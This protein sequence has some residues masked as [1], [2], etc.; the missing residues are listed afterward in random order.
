MTTPSRPVMRYL[1]GKWRLAPWII[2]FFPA[3]RT[4]VEPF[5]GAASV[6]LRK[7]RAHAEILNDLDGE[8]VNLFRVLRSP[9]DGRELARQ[10]R[11]TPFARREYEAAFLSAGDPIEQA[12]RTL[13][14][15]AMG[16]GSNS[17][18]KRTG[19]RPGHARTGQIPAGD[20]SGL[21]ASLEQAIERLRGVVVE[22]R[23]ALEVIRRYDSAKTLHY[24]DPPYPHGARGDD[25]RYRCEMTD[26][27]HAELAEALHVVRGMVIVSGYGCDLYDKALYA[28][29]QR[30][31]VSTHADGGR[32]RQEVLW[33]KPGAQIAPR[34]FEDTEADH[35]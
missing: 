23:P 28:D 31:E 9:I 29:W 27:E 6:L 35:G 21:P 3:H 30:V 5:G 24:I 22:E 17:V 15:A 2:S 11:Y 34:L 20:W 32:D 7:P 25:C 13:V 18:H 19:F 8:I 33:I 1:G 12:R 10:V 16:F 26:G 4:Y 14:K